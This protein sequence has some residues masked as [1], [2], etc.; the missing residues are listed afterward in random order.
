MKLAYINEPGKIPFL[1][2][3]GIYIVEKKTG[4]KMEPAR[5]LAWYPKVAISSGILE[6]LVAHTEQGLNKRL[7]QLIRMQV[8]ILVNCN[9]CIDMNGNEFEKQGITP[10]E[11][12]V[13]QGLRNS[14]EV[15]S[16]TIQERIAIQYTKE[17]TNT[18]LD[19]NINTIELMKQHFNERQFV[20]IVSTVA[21]VNYWARL[22][23][24]FGIPA[25][26][27]RED[28]DINGK[29]QEEIK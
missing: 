8:S 23:K 2:K 13:L 9:F 28:C 27:F 22:I 7:L 18:P 15:H 20:I 5:I 14:E 4:K 19:E 3:F 10:E 1:L 26:G 25:A 24:G 16:L 12:E 21:Q 11:V 17:V 6:S 29:Q